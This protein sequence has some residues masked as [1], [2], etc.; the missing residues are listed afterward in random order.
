MNFGKSAMTLL[1]TSALAISA[2]CNADADKAAAGAAPAKSTPVAS[3][4]PSNPQQVHDAIMA[5]LLP[6]IEAAFESRNA[7]ARW[8]GKVLH[9]KMDGKTNGVMPGFTECRVLSHFLE[10][11]QT[12]VLEFPDATLECDDVLRD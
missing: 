9:V 2:G 7:K 11:G 5:Q 10:D 4:D 3:V 1:L 8:E 12:A 6:G